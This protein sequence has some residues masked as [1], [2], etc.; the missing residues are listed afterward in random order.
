MPLT[1]ACSILFENFS[2]NNLKGDLSNVTTDNPTLFSLVN[3]FKQRP[4]HTVTVNCTVYSISRAIPIPKYN[5]SNLETLSRY[6]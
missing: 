3:T 5:K 6:C 2:E 4:K 1:G